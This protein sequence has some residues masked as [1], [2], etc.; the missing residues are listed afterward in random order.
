MAKLEAYSCGSGVREGFPLHLEGSDSINYLEM[1]RFLIS[2][3]SKT[4]VFRGYQ[5][6][7]AVINT[8]K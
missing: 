2:G 3:I 6:G 8:L 7:V 1:G 4:G 5:P